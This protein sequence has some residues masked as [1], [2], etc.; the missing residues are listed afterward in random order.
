[1]NISLLCGC[2]TLLT[3]LGSD[4]FKK[5]KRKVFLEVKFLYPRNLTKEDAYGTPESCGSL[6][7][8]QGPGPGILLLLYLLGIALIHTVEQVHRNK[9]PHIEW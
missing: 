5:K 1:M 8:I 3:Y 6:P 2:V 9:S 4:Q 7:V